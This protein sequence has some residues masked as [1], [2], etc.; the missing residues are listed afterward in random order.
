MK[1]LM[2]LT[3]MGFITF[4]CSNDQIE[5]CHSVCETKS[6]P[7]PDYN[8]TKEDIA[9]YIKYA[10]LAEGSNYR[11]MNIIYSIENEPL[12]YAI[13]YD[14]GWE[15]ISSD[16]RTQAVIAKCESGSFYL[17]SINENMMSNLNCLSEELL[18]LKNTHMV[19]DEN[20][21]IRDI[22]DKN[23]FFWKAINA[24]Q[25]VF[26]DSIVQT[27]SDEDP[28]T[29]GHWELVDVHTDYLYLD[30]TSKLTTT[31]W[32]QTENIEYPN[33]LNGQYCNAY[34]PLKSDNSG[35]RAPAGCEAVA[36]AQMVFYFHNFFGVPLTSPSYAIC[37]GTTSYY[38][39]IIGSPSQNVWPY[40]QTNSTYNGVYTAAALIAEV[41]KS[42]GIMYGNDQSGASL[43]NLRDGFIDMGFACSMDE[44]DED[45][46]INSLRDSIPVVCRADGTRTVIAG[47]PFF[48]NG[49]CFIIDG[50]KGSQSMKTYTYA[51]VYD[52]PD[53]TADQPAELETIEIHYGT[54]NITHFYMNWGF[55]DSEDDSAQMSLSLGWNMREWNFIYNRG[56]IYGFETE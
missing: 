46:V 55:A 8:V 50:Y 1:K 11:S 34:C 53:P 7:L 10:K 9:A 39:Q 4:S 33:S 17:N 42:I 54:P 6:A 24:D 32:G 13:N 2:I 29:S 31:H 41:G 40:M 3:I 51:W 44:Y 38:Q 47:Y 20:E 56:I 36:G 48:N 12:F 28:A 18:V 23:L 22:I 49:H 14:E 26:N 21:E 19:K 43:S 16:K 30:E 5:I 45:T 35:L 37:T 27:K 15:L 52:N 25:S